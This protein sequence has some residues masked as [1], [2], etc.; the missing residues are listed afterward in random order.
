MFCKLSHLPGCF[1]PWNF[2]QN[3]GFN[4]VL[5][6]PLYVTSSYPTWILS[7]GVSGFA[8]ECTCDVWCRGLTICLLA[9]WST[10]WK[11]TNKQQ[12][13][14]RFDILAYAI[15]YAKLRYLWD[16]LDLCCSMADCRFLR[17]LGLNL[18]HLQYERLWLLIV[19]VPSLYVPVCL[20]Y[21][22]LAISHRTLA[23]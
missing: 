6:D 2:F 21:L 19:W 14:C 10:F 4:M 13:G 1:C 7:R 9:C 12:L 11:S 5:S 22:P 18:Y 20:V 8:T 23:M 3:I 17:G 15:T 16:P